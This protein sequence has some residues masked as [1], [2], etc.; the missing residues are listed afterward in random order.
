[1]S[2]LLQINGLEMAYGTQTILSDASLS[3]SERQKVAVV[4]RNGAGKSTLFRLI[5]GEEEPTGGK[6][7][8]HGDT[9]IGYLTQHNPFKEGETVMDFLT[10]TSGKESWDCAK[11]AA[12]FQIKTGLFDR[13]V[14][15]LPGGYQMRVKLSAILAKEPNLLLLDEPTNYLDLSTLLLLEHFLKKYRGAFMLI[16]HDREFIKKTCEQTLEIEQGRTILFPQPLE[17]YLAY[18]SE[19]TLTEEKFNKKVLQEKQHLQTFVDRFGAKASKAAQAKA[20]MKQIGKLQTIEILHPLS[21]SKIRIPK[22]ET[23][24]GTALTVDELSIGYP[25]KT[26]ADKITFDINRG[27]R[28]AIVGDNG[29]GKTTFLKTIAG[30]LAAIAGKY[31]WGSNIRISYYA[32]HTPATMDSTATVQEYLLREATDGIS[33]EDIFEMAGNFLFKDE[34]LKKEISV[35]SGGEKARLCLAS[36]LLKKSHVLLLDEPTNHLDFETVEALAEALSESNGTIFFV[37]H[38]RTFVETLA[39]GIIEVKNGRAARYHHDYENYVYHIQKDIEQDLQEES[40][41]KKQ[42]ESAAP[43][44]SPTASPA[45]SSAASQDGRSMLKKAKNRIG[46]IESAIARLEEEKKSLLTWFETHH[47]EYSEEK[48]LRMGE[49]IKLLESAE[50]DWI[51][52]QQEI[53][54][55]SA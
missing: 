32:Q 2:I 33:R 16:S 14:T 20:K 40:P 28:I 21:T 13:E 17:E 25:G 11:V 37:S 30:E 12:Q 34:S 54:G 5:I 44:T 8:I 27:E 24:K 10:R 43:A 48:S 9:R 51:K 36:I 22:V 55:L 50:N 23:K 46:K 41:V 18:K 39:N 7:M 53:E 3:I 6:I 15:S 19:K 31:N 49:I 4:G 35:L 52:V 29:Q 45:A 1:M 47:S 42:K 38:N 26:V